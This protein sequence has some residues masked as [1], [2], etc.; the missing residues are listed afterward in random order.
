MLTM[1]KIPE[2]KLSHFAAGIVAFSFFVLMFNPSSAFICAVIT[3][4]LKEVYDHFFG[5]TVDVWDA[6]VTGLGGLF[7]YVVYLLIEV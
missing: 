4:V 1:I 7:I 5:G 3:G 2:D 6:I